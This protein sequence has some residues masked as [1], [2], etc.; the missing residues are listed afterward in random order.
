[1]RKW[2]PFHLDHIRYAKCCNFA[3][4]LGAQNVNRCN[5]FYFY[6]N[7]LR[8]GYKL[9]GDSSK[10]R[11]NI[12]KHGI[13]FE[14]AF[15]LFELPNKMILELYDFEQSLN[16]DRIISIR[17]VFRGVIVI[18]SVEWLMVKFLY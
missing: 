17:P 18:V 2:L 6:S 9:Y 16:E 3:V 5:G 12:K 15:E 1:M 14:E 7:Y 4:T 13:S 10:N 8:I 11:D